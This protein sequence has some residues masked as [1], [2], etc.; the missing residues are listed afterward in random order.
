MFE[1]FKNICGLVL[2]RAAKAPLPSVTLCWT[3][4]PVWACTASGAEKECVYACVRVRYSFS[5]VFPSIVFG[6]CLHVVC[7]ECGS[8]HHHLC[9][10]IP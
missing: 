1:V 3:V 7:L 6:L 2:T 5:V 10:D 8:P 9:H 4:P